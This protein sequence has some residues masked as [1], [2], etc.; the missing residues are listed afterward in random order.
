[1]YPSRDVMFISALLN[2]FV[3]YVKRSLAQVLQWRPLW[4]LPQGGTPPCAPPGCTFEHRGCAENQWIFF[5][6]SALGVWWFSHTWTFNFL[7]RIVLFQVSKWNHLWCLKASLAINSI[8]N[9]CFCQNWPKCTWKQIFCHYSQDYLL[10]G[11]NQSS[12][13]CWLINHT[14]LSKLASN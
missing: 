12:N 6:K 2:F 9:C 13:L 1:M 7:E 8:I 11:K 4:T 3:L 5:L 10:S 14:V